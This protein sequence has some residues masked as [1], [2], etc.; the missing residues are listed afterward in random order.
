VAVLPPAH[1]ISARA[2][3]F[4]TIRFVP[5]NDHATL[6]RDVAATHLRLSVGHD[7]LRFPDWASA[8]LDSFDA[9]MT[10]S[11]KREL[12]VEGTIVL[13]KPA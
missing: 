9:A 13:S 4:E 1:Q 8:I 3:G 12:M 2:A 10:L 11:A 7:D 5:H 6:Y